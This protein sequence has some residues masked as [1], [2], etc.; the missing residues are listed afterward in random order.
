MNIFLYSLHIAGLKETGCCLFYDAAKFSKLKS[1]RDEYRDSAFVQRAFGDVCLTYQR[2]T[3]GG[4]ILDC[5]TLTKSSRFLCCFF[6]CAS[7]HLLMH[8]RAPLIMS[9]HLYNAAEKQKAVAEAEERAKEAEQRAQEA[10]ERALEAERRVF[11]T[12]WT[13]EK[14]KKSEIQ[15]A[16][17]RA[18]DLADEV[19]AEAEQRA[20]AAERKVLHTNLTAK[21]QKISLEHGK[22]L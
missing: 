15:Q 12:N 22:K 4:Q 11:Q 3:R 16:K 21:E 18:Q 7:T 10:E 19:V 14:E 8:A 6:I 13:V 2:R 1:I 9:G 20:L 5:H 17:Q